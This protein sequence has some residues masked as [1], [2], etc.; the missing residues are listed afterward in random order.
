MTPVS[1]LPSLFVPMT[2]KELVDY[3]RGHILIEIGKGKYEQAVYDAVSI[4]WEKGALAQQIRDV[5]R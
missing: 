1:N 4:A 5:S 3:M 2:L